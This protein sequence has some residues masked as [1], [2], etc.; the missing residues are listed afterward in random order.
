LILCVASLCSHGGGGGKKQKGKG[1][2]GKGKA[3]IEQPNDS[4]TAAEMARLSA[5]ERKKAAKEVRWILW[6]FL[7]TWTHS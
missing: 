7:V 2:K 3:S 5:K 6:I 1:P 4:P